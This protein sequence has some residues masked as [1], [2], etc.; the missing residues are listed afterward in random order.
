MLRLVV[1]VVVVVRDAFTTS[2]CVY[3]PIKGPFEQQ[4]KP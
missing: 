2:L 4:L 3:G 1:V